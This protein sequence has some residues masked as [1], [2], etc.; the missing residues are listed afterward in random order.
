M[1]RGADR[2]LGGGRLAVAARPGSPA[3]RAWQGKRPS[4]TPTV[5]R[6]RSARMEHF[7][8]QQSSSVPGVGHTFKAYPNP[9]PD[10]FKAYPN[11][12]PTLY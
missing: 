11:P 9:N 3:R 1:A 10:T 6:T 4:V 5:T 7:T 12:D 2:A 8:L